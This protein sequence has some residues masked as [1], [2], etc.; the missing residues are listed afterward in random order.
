MW[1]IHDNDG[2]G[3][4][5][6]VDRFFTTSLLAVLVEIIDILL[7]DGADGDHHDLDVRAGGEVAHLSQ[8]G[9]VVNEVIQ[10]HTGIQS[11]EMVFSDLQ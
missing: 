8:L 4:L 1:F 11:L 5:N 6:Q 2:T 3:C 10:R 9:G 7:V